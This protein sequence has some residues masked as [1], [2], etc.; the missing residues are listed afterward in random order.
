MCTA[1]ML[2]RVQGIRTSGHNKEGLRHPTRGAVA[3]C[4]L[5]FESGK[6]VTEVAAHTCADLNAS[7]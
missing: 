1:V 3:R 5:R 2:K 6:S 4:N 7:S